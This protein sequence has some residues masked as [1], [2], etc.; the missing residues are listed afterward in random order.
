MWHL[1]QLEVN[2]MVMAPSSCHAYSAMMGNSLVMK[3]RL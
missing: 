1:R 3:T 2:A